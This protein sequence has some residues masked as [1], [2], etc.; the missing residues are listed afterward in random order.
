MLSSVIPRTLPGQTAHFVFVYQS[1]NQANG[2]ESWS[3]WHVYATPN[4]AITCPIL[5][6]AHYLFSNPGILTTFPVDREDWD[7]NLKIDLIDPQKNISNMSQNGYTKFY[8]IWNQYCWFM[9]CF[10]KV[11]I[12]NEELFLYLGVE[13]GDLRSHLARKGRSFASSWSNVSPPIVS[14]CLYAMWSMGRVKEWYLHYEKNC[15]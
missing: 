11:V 13:E 4:N 5:V 14:V 2:K 12:E 9:K 15:I 7:P 10:H 1:Q 8:P 6:L 3:G